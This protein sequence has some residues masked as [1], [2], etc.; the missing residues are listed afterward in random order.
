MKL[1]SAV[2]ARISL[3]FMGFFLLGAASSAVAAQSGAVEAPIKVGWQDFKPMIY[4]EGGV[5]KGTYV[6]TRNELLAEAGLEYTDIFY[7]QISR[8]YHQLKIGKGVVDAWVSSV[9]PSLEA[10]G[11]PVEPTTFAPI[12]MQLFGLAGNKPPSIEDLNEKVLVTVIGFKF[13]G[14]PERLG[15]EKPLMRIVKAATHKAAF[16]MLKARRAPY[17]LDYREPALHVARKLGI[18]D[19]SSTPIADYP[20]FFYVSRN[21]PLMEQ[22]VARISAASKR[23]LARREALKGTLEK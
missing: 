16:Q 10:L 20:I 3:L 14:L 9:H 17:V 5:T 13:S 4:S 7:P 15:L 6:T 23:I 1:I 19:V 21:H 8:L 11:V 18:G 12:H 2:P 22:L